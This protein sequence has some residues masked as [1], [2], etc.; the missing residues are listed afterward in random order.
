[1]ILR[2]LE[3]RIKKKS[4]H[5]L[6]NSQNGP[7]WNPFRSRI[8]IKYR[9]SNYALKS[10]RATQR[11]LKQK[12]W[13]MIIII[14]LWKCICTRIEKRIRITLNWQFQI[15]SFEIIRLIIWPVNSSG[16]CFKYSG[17]VYLIPDGMKNVNEIRNMFAFNIDELDP[18]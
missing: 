7:T 3:F 15:G 1:M 10:K 9:R 8:R 2:I 13:I 14:Y 11:K 4:V 5:V 16:D 17:N 12:I 6:Y 18:I